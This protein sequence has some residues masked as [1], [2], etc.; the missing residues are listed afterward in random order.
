MHKSLICLSVQLLLLA[1][2]ATQRPQ[3]ASCPPPPQLPALQKLPQSVTA[4]SF[5][6]ELE[7]ILLPSQPVGIKSDYSLRPAKHS[8]T[9]PG[10]R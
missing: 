7:A 8:T 3:I 10:V 5:L 2:C 1:G 6:N 9:Q 4:G